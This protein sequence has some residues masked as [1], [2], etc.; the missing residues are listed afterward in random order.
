VHEAV[1]SVVGRLLERINDSGYL[2]RMPMPS[3]K[4]HKTLQDRALFPKNHGLLKN[5]CK[6][7]KDSTFTFASIKQKQ[8][9]RSNT[10]CQ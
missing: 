8:E 3:Y 2:F 5:R 1:T 9:S 6:Q 10:T 4:R 7:V